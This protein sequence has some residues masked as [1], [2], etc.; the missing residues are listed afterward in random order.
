MTNNYLTPHD[1]FFRSAMANPRV[2]REFFEHNL[3]D[4]IKKI[5]NFKKLE[6]KKESFIDDK[7]KLQIT[8]LLFATEFNCHSG[9][10]YL[11]VEHQSVPH[12]LMPFRLLKYSFAIMEHHLKNTKF[13]QLPIVFP[14]VFYNGQKK[15]NHSTNIFDLFADKQLAENIF[16]KPFQLIDLT[17]IS[18][19][20]FKNFLH[21]GVL[22]K[23]MKHIFAKDFLPVFKR[24]IIELKGLEN[25]GELEY[26]Y[27]ILSYIFTAGRI[28]DLEEFRETV[29]SG[30][31]NVDEEKVMTLAELCR[32]EGRKIGLQEGLQQGRQEGKREGKREGKQEALQSVIIALELIKQ[33]LSVKQIAART[34]LPIAEIEK[35]KKQIN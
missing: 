21:Y 2:A 13:K 20:Q 23:T 3:P 4:N 26:I 28:I 30:L 15:Y 29:K 1:R 19:E 16:F 24:L 17:Q 10:I 7:L 8:D 27:T 6:I 33:N 5:I 11:L 32:R 12:K 14:M 34:N 31:S 25:D 22:A 18:D 35:I 9:Y